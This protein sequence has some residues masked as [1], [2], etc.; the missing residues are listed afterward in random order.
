MVPSLEKTKYMR[1]AIEDMESVGSVD[2][3]MDSEVLLIGEFLISLH[4]SIVSLTSPTIFKSKK[5]RGRPSGGRREA[6]CDR[7]R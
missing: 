3:V 7:G 4:C 5:G 1:K 2:E 6:P